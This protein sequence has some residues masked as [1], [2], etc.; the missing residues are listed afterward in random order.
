MTKRGWSWSHQHAARCVQ[1][2]RVHILNYDESSLRAGGH[3]R[4]QGVL[5]S[6]QPRRTALP[7]DLSGVRRLGWNR[8][9]ISPKCGAV[10]SMS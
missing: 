8:Q 1:E 6:F 4:P 9:G 3:G 2:G 5:P 10:L 7:C